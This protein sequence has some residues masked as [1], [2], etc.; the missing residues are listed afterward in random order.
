MDL[1]VKEVIRG[2]K[3]GCHYIRVTRNPAFQTTGEHLVA[4]EDVLLPT[5]PLGKV[6]DRL[7]RV[8]FG[9]RIPTEREI[10]ERVNVL[11]GL[12]V[13]AS[14]NISSSAYA[15]EE[16]MRVLVLAGTGLLTLTMPITLLI[17]LRRGAYVDF[18]GDV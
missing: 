9:A 18:P 1:R 17:C 8:V 16:I 3:P 5:T 15:T 11:K 10:H 4:R 7:R 14:D 13:F 6:L 12:A 2:S